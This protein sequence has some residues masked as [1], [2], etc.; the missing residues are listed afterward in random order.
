[1][2]CVMSAM[3]GKDEFKTLHFYCKFCDR[4]MS[5]EQDRECTATPELCQ[6]GEMLGYDE[7]SLGTC[8]KCDRDLSSKEEG[9]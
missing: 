2:K 9:K 5:Y 7:Y 8:F 4:E 1:M 3:Y 6:C